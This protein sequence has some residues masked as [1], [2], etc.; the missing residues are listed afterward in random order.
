MTAAPQIETFLND[1]KTAFNDGRLV[2]LKLMGYQGP[3]AALKSVA[4]KKIVVKR[5]D[6]L[7][8]TYRYK[9]RDIIKNHILPEAMALL[10]ADLGAVFRTALLETTEFDLNFEQHGDKVRIKRRD[11][12]RDVPSTSHDRTKHRLIAPEGKSLSACAQNRG[13]ARQCAQ[14]CTG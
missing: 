2:Q 1:V 5:Q 10:R 7:S 12:N 3:D 13:C 9:T 14:G 8:F 11:A 4:I 6:M